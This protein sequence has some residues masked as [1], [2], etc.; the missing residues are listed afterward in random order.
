MTEG[1]SDKFRKSGQETRDI[2][3]HSQKPEISPAQG[4]KK[5]TRYQST[6]MDVPKAAK[7]SGFSPR[8]FRRFIANG[9]ISVINFGTLNDP[10]H[11]ILTADFYEWL[12]SRK[13][14]E[15]EK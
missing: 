4:S 3:P 13:R 12:A 10:R 11:K 1:K 6:F 5:E 2:D 9:E 7:L 8:K 14:K 15:K